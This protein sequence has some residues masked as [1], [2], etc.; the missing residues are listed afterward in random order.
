VLQRLNGEVNTEFVP[1]K[2]LLPTQ[3]WP[4][5]TLKLLKELI[6]GNLKSMRYIRIA[7]TEST[8]L[9]HHIDTDDCIGVTLKVRGRYP[10]IL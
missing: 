6:P 9:F 4:L 5:K 7:I 8:S 1:A 2:Y 3:K 10:A